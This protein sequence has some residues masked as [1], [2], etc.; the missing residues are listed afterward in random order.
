[1]SKPTR[2]EMVDAIIEVG[3]Y[4]LSGADAINA[5]ERIWRRGY[6]GETFDAMA[7]D[8]VESMY[9]HLVLRQY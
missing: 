7:D 4:G 6:D 9:R 2:E 5:L 8:D 1:M 3:M